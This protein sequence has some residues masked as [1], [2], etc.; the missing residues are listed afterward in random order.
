MK[1]L[2]YDDR[3]SIQAGLKAGLNFSQIAETIGKNRSTVSREV[4]N[5]RIQILHESSNICMHR[6]DCNI[7]ESCTYAKNECRPFRRCRTRCSLCNSTCDRFKPEICSLTDRPP[8]V[9]NGCTKRCHLDKWKYDAKAAQKNYEKTL[10][11]S[12]IGISLSDEDLAFLKEHIVP[13]IKN[14]LS[15]PI[16]CE[17]YKDRMPVCTKTM[18]SY[19]NMR[20]FEIDNLHLRLKVRRPLHR[21]SGP[22][23][24][25]DKQCYQNRTYEDYLAY[26]EAH[27]QAVVCQ[28][29]TVEGK[30]GGKVMLTIYFPTCGL[31]LM[32]LR[33]RN[34]AASVTEIFQRLRK[35]LGQ[36]FTRLF[37]VILTDRG[38]EFSDPTAIET[39]P[40]TGETDCRVFYCDPLQSNQKSECERNHELIRYIF[41]KGHSLNRF[42]QE[43]VTLAMNHINSTP[44]EKWAMQVPIVMFGDLYGP[45]VVQ[46]LG[47]VK[48]KF[49]SILLRPELVK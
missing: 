48:I 38:T 6:Y 29:D 25:V 33:E 24:K 43:K 20:L 3:L 8:Y 39:N 15:V 1:H 11:E 22:V 7:P 5:Q 47:L 28:M 42:D 31:Q 10:R 14:G 27:P 13:L 34:D 36:D 41:P 45:Q 32:Y 35:Q 23:L 44:R 18:Y 17:A 16:V 19:I 12:R 21:K 4:K 2:T 30:K 9:C 37:Q 49:E 40:M 26:I 46:K